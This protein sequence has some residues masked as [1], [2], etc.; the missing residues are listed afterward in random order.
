M[1]LYLPQWHSQSFTGP[2]MRSQQARPRLQGVRVLGENAEGTVVEVTGPDGL[3]WTLMT[4]NG[5][6]SAS[7]THRVAA[8]ETTHEWTGN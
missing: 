6:A 1:R 3:R 8:G 2:K 7:A 4:T 5:G